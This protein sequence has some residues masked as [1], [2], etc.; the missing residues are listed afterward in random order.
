MGA[1]DPEGAGRICLKALAK[2]A[3]ERYST[4][5]DMADDLR[6]FFAHASAD[7]KQCLSERS[8]ETVCVPG[9]HKPGKVANPTEDPPQQDSM[10]AK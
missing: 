1:R 4:A 3:S 9:L 8:Y 2:W 6:H 10:P 7:E 5:K